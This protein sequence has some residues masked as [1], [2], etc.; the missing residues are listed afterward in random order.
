MAPETRRRPQG[1]WHALG[2][3]MRQQSLGFAGAIVLIL[4]VLA[5]L[6]A[7]FVA[8]RN[9]LETNFLSQ[10]KAPGGEFLLGTDQFGRDV[11]SR[12]IFGARTALVVGFASS[13]V[14]T[15]FGAILG[16]V[17]AYFGDPADLLIQ[18]LMDILQAF[19]NIILAIAVLA[20]VGNGT[21]NVILAL[22][23]P[24]IPYATRL[25]RASALT[26]RTMPYVEAARTVG[27]THARIILLHMLPN[28]TAPILIVLTA[29][30]GQAILLEAGLSFL[31]LGVTEPTASWG[32]ML[33]GGGVKY[34][35]SAPWLA[36]APGLAISL[37]V[38]AFNLLGDALR[39]AL[40]P[41]LRI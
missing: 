5:A 41:R 14:S 40:D 3:M 39:D 29:F 24:M 30:L 21:L 28:V 4:M 6:L 15:A 7:D 18:R 9:P 33:R 32:L 26:V 10:L 8:P 23:V 17:S 13:F 2:R 11:L 25:V 35:E 16:I 34:A 12:I 20:V 37:A 36:L 27:A 31:G 19:P 1:R 38:L 22:I